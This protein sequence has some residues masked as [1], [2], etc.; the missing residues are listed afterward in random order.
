M[1]F[2]TNIDRFIHGI[3][4]IFIFLLIQN[5]VESRAFVYVMLHQKSAYMTYKRQKM[6][7]QAVIEVERSIIDGTQA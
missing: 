6:L 4:A 1:T 2:Q 5:E 7:L 3:A